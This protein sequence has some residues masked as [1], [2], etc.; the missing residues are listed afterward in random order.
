V[1]VLVPAPISLVEVPAVFFLAVWVAVHLLVLVTRP[2]AFWAFLGALALG[3]FVARV[4]RRPL[5]W[6]T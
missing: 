6:E 5:R 2:G 4:T 1:L 3:A